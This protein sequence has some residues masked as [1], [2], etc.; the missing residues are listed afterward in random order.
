ML[1][2][3]AISALFLRRRRGA[4]SV[5]AAG[6]VPWL[7]ADGGSASAGASPAAAAA[8]AVLRTLR[9]ES[10]EGAAVPPAAVVAA[11]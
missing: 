2:S 10:A 8:D 6:A 1:P 7:G 5:S 11:A 4:A 9:F 3:A